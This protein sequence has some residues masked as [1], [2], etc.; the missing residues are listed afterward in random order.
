M[1]FS[2]DHSHHHSHKPDHKHCSSHIVGHTTASAG[3][4]EDYED[5]E[6]FLEWVTGASSQAVKRLEQLRFRAA[7]N[8]AWSDACKLDNGVHAIGETPV[9]S[10][11]QIDLFLKRPLGLNG[12]KAVP[13][14]A[15]RMSLQLSNLKI[16]QHGHG[17]DNDCLRSDNEEAVGT[18]GRYSLAICQRCATLHCTLRE[19]QSATDTIQLHSPISLSFAC[20]D[21]QVRNVQ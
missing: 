11:W 16:L 3:Q 19:A 4:V 12:Q 2:G 5:V 13:V 6:A 15:A 9:S 1:G 18:A 10:Q 20:E 8:Q 21:L 7:G 17:K 14:Q